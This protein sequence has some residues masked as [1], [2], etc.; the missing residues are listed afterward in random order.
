MFMG[1]TDGR[2]RLLPAIGIVILAVCAVGAGS[3]YAGT[4]RKVKEGEIYLAQGHLTRMEAPLNDRMVAHAS[5]LFNEI[6]ESYLEPEQI[7]P[8]LAVIPDKNYYLTDDRQER[9]LDYEALVRAYTR[10]N[11]YMTY[12][13][14]SQLLTLSDYYVTD[15]HW[16]QEYITDVADFLAA[17]MGTALNDEYRVMKLN[18][19]FYGAFYE[20]GENR[21]SLDTICYLDSD[22]LESCTVTDIGEG[23]PLAIY[24]V[25]KAEEGS[26]YDLFLSGTVA[27][28]SIDNPNATSN[29]RLIIFR[30]SYASCLAPLLLSGY[31][32]I[33][34]IDIRYVQSKELGALVDFSD[35]DV[36]FLYSTLLL[37]NSMG[38]K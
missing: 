13:D 29:K 26:A 30:D 16:R 35:A 14:I 22:L 10:A 4:H 11:P 9:A 38:M 32:Q 19:P 2:G 21:V 18:E 3:F 6:Y 24:D 33:V 28:I 15:S 34:L 8:Y 17:Q 5:Q 36:L 37:N 20:E 12:L 7:A 23:K 25:E 27:L 1:R 31:R